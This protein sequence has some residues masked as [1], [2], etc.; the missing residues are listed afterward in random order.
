MT[1]YKPGEEIE[2]VI[3]YLEM[4]R[5]PEYPLPHPI[6]LPGLA[7]IRAEDPPVRWFL[8]LYR[9]VGEAHEWTDWL[10]ADPQE[11]DSFVG[12]E[13][14]AIYTLMLQ[15]WTAGFFMLDWREEGVTDLAYFGLA[16]EAQGRGLGAWLLKNAIHFAW[17]VPGTGTVT[18][19]TCTL[20]GARAL[21]LYQKLGF[22]PVRQKVC[23]RVLTGP[24][25]RQGGS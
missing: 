8:H 6:P 5:R 1:D 9:S 10:T 22:A 4:T 23:R 24:W 16:P 14:V 15:G 11:L 13:K 18:V 12:D 3:T 17:D 19:N 20:D 2:V 25:P 21:P 7:L